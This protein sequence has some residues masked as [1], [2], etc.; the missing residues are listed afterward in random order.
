MNKVIREILITAVVALL[1]FMGVRMVIHN[2]EVQGFSMEPNLHDGQRVFVIKAAYWFGEPQ[3]GDVVVFDTERFS[4]DIIHRI[5]GLPGEVVEIRAGVLYV[6]GERLDEP[7]TQ[8]HTVTAPPQKVP[9]DSYFI[10]GDNRG[11]AGW[12][13]V[14]KKAII[15]KAWLSYWPLGEWGTVENYSWEAGA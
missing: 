4:E 1:L 8:G 14:P 3:R 11:V 10:V 5:A 6:N 12:D 13:I 15:G 2:A 7:Y 9:E